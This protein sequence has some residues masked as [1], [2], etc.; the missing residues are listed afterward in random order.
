MNY[1]S[2]VDWIR[3]VDPGY[4][5]KSKT[6]MGY[7]SKDIDEGIVVDGG[8]VMIISTNEYVE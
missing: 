3:S 6:I 1:G 8:K 5:T 7:H 4:E 2:G